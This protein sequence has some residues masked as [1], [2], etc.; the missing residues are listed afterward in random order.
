MWYEDFENTK[1]LGY[2]KMNLTILQEKNVTIALTER[3]FDWTKKD[4]EHYC[5]IFI[6]EYGDF[7]SLIE[8]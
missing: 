7:R 3:I 1:E 5:A 8:L 6:S 4:D 2:L